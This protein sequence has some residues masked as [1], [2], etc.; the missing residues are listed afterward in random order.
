M[1]T[2]DVAA[3][4]RGGGPAPGVNEMKKKEISRKLDNII[5]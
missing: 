4:E 1:P 5:T 3:A 2:H